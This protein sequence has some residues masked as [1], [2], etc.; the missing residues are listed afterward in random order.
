MPLTEMTM[1]P[2]STIESYVPHR[3]GML[4]VDAIVSADQTSIEVEARVR[5]DRWY[6]DSAGAMPAWIGIELM[7]QTVAAHVGHLSHMRGLPPKQGVLLGTRC[8]EST[9]PVFA[10]DTALRVKAIEV[11]Q[12]AAGF[13]AY[14]CEI[15]SGERLLASASLKVFQPDDFR[16]FVE[17]AYA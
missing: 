10:A 14:D 13:G 1:T 6:S 3:D 2:R 15:C 12:D 17:S 7:A 5:P 16:S 11:Y 8:Y 4:L 9:T